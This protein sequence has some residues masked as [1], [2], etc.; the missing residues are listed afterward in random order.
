[1]RTST[2]TQT[3]C[4]LIFT[5]FAFHCYSQ[6][7][8][9]ETSSES[10][11]FKK[12]EIGLET[13]RNEISYYNTAC[14]FALAGKQALAFSYLGKSM[15]DGF[16]NMKVIENDTDLLLL[17]SDPRWP[18]MLK[19]VEGNL[20][21]KERMSG[22]F[23]NKKSFWESSAF[24][25]PY[26]E[27]LTEDEKVAGLSKF[28]SEVRYNFVNF[29]LI[30]DVNFDS[31]YFAYLPKVRRTTST[32]E[33][34][35]LLEEFC[36]KLRDGHTNVL[37]PAELTDSVYARPLLRTRLIEDKVLIIGIYD[38]AL[39][40]K[41]LAVGQEIVKVNGLPVKDYA[42]R[43]VTPTQISSTPQYKL[44]RVFDFALFK[45]SLTEPINL[46]VRNASN[47]ISEHAIYRV[48]PEVRSRKLQMPA[49]AYRML[50]GNIA[51][52][53][54]NS[55]AND[56]TAIQFAAKFEE[57]SKAK[58]IIFDVRNNGGGST[59]PGWTILSYLI[60]K[61]TLIHST[62]TR[63]YRPTHRAWNYDQEI[64]VDKNSLFPHEKLLYTKPVVVLT[65]PRTFSAAEDFAAAFKTMNRG[66]IIGEPTGGS[67]GQ[68][69]LVTL[70]GNGTAIICTKRD[71][72]GN[73]ED[74]VGKGV[75]PDKLVAPS[76]NDIRKGID[77]ELQMAI[78]E[79]TK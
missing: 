7:P 46:Q 65:S 35:S 3:L 32:L 36:V 20:A 75:I 59:G 50:E 54:L 47:K 31:L 66:L 78:S 5:L 18:A 43:Y 29:D 10:E 53:A 27:N 49:F 44:V 45:G 71:M 28:W 63:Q 1:M 21:M 13:G 55:F 57:I 30:P 39:S 52:V 70:P 60:D 40:Q 34:Y 15:D 61:P 51:Y 56:S 4:C 24:Q 67:S 16:S 23:F 37:M 2:F 79:L 38:P 9:T 58:A 64:V 73:G 76:V 74:F 14:Y 17:H 12:L 42:A 77:T 11:A 22:L 48:K 69:L 41:G 26:R 62:Y 8:T 25:T 33:Y 68:P 72:L 19:R 6:E